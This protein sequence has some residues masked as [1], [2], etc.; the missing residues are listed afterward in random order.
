MYW[1][2]TRDLKSV[3]E[4]F[5]HFKEPGPLKW[6]KNDAPKFGVPYMPI[7]L[8]A[9]PLQG[10]TYS[11]NT[12]QCSIRRWVDMVVGGWPWSSDAVFSRI[13]KTARSEYSIH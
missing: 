6:A 1:L 3:I 9:R 13:S 4:R 5:V 11:T 12:I 10:A 7:S 2:F 8:I